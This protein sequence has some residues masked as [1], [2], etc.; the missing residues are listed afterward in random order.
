[1]TETEFELAPFGWYPDPAGSD[2][3]RWWNGHQWT[4]DLERARPE[5]RPAY[6]YNADGSV[7][8]HHDY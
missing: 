1:M 6:G 2:M 8:Q 4:T 5:I 3:L 7:T